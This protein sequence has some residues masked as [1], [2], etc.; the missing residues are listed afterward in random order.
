MKCGI[1]GPP[2]VGKSSLFNSLIK[3]EMASVANY[4]FC[5]ID[6]NVASVPY[7]DE[8]LDKIH[9][10]TGSKK[11]VP[12][13]LSFVDIAG[14][15]KEAASNV[16]LGNKF[17]ST[18]ASVDVIIQVV[19]CFTDDYIGGEGKIQGDT[20]PL[21]DMEYVMLELI[22]WDLRMWKSYCDRDKKNV[23]INKLLLQWLQDEKPIRDFLKTIDGKTLD[24]YKGTLK[25]ISIITDKPMIIAANISNRDADGDNI[26]KVEEKCNQLG[27]EMAIVCGNY[28]HSTANL[29]QE[30][31]EEVLSL[32]GISNDGLD[33]LVALAFKASGLIQFFTTGVEET[34]SWNIIKGI[35]AQNA[36][37]AIHTDI[38]DNFITAEVINWQVLINNGGWNNCK[39]MGLIH[40]EG[41]TYI[42]QDGDIIVFKHGTRKK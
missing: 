31:Q 32:I 36:A 17:L 33:N 35:D 39:T 11:I 37:S 15:V 22:L 3:K 34:R 7:N 8:R 2:N 4:A 28:Y 30:E 13:Y 12:S 38:S 29:A 9:Q 18:M 27:L 23:E 26:K 5:T 25:N 10:I 16:G 19:R 40:N 1:I 6:P 14:I 21:N 41:K 20:D 42:V 24:Y